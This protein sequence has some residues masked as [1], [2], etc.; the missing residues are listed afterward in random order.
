MFYVVS[1][2]ISDDD[3][4]GRV[5]AIL[6]NYGTR[7]QYSVFECELEPAQLGQLQARLSRLVRSDEDNLRYYRLCKD[8]LA[9]TTIVGDR[10]LTTDPDH[11]IV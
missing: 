8:C 3:R 5:H 1:Y 11:W 7:V 6:L 2:D 9:Q 10:P 4:R